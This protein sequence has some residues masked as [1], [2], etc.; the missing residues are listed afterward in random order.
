MISAVERASAHL[1]DDGVEDRAVALDVRAE[2]SRHTGLGLHPFVRN[3]S[4]K[5]RNAA[6]GK[7]PH[8][9]RVDECVESFIRRCI[10]W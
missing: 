1:G 9:H 4:L 6:F 7:R 2:L 8:E 5:P 10:G 3:H